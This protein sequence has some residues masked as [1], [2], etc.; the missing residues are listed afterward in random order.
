MIKEIRLK[1]FKAFGKEQTFELAPLTLLFGR[2]S[3][4]KST[5]VQAMQLLTQSIRHQNWRI[6]PS[7]EGRPKLELQ[8]Y[9]DGGEVDLGDA[10]SCLHKSAAET[11]KDPKPATI[12]F[13]MEGLEN[14]TIMREK[15]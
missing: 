10:M 5:M 2:N 9:V 3:V 6:H 12:T 11:G 15:W 4:G 13:Q 8:P 1:N 14:P 7:S